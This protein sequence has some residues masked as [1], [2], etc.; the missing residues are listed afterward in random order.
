[1]IKKQRQT[2]QC[3]TLS[4]DCSNILQIATSSFSLF[5][6]YIFSRIFLQS[7]VP[8]FFSHKKEFQRQYPALFPSS[9]IFKFIN[10]T[11]L[12]FFHNENHLSLFLH[13]ISV[14]LLLSTILPLSQLSGRLFASS[15]CEG[16]TEVT[17]S[18]YRR[19]SQCSLEP[20]VDR[21]GFH[22]S[23]A[24]SMLDCLFPE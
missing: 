12:L 24:L 20:R 5:H 16:N 2:L 6:L 1:M 21:N 7:I 9:I 23:S 22:Y 17:G 18:V 11:V 3:R 14:S 10:F 15:S 19:R 8:S 4:V 13:F